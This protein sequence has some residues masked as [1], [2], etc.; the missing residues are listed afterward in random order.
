[1][2]QTTLGQELEPGDVGEAELLAAMDWLHGRQDQIESTLAGRHLKGEA[3]VLYDLSSSYLEGRLCELA[4]IGYS[5]DGKPAKLQI[6][7]GAKAP[8]A[9]LP[10]TRGPTPSSGV[11]I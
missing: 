6:S 3:Y 2:H 7:Y 1:M 9:P 10:A 4:Q 8:T 11:S 5:R